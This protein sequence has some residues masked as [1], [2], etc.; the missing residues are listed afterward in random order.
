M[1]LNSIDKNRLN[2]PH[3]GEEAAGVMKQQCNRH[4]AK[5]KDI[6]Q[7]ME[8]VSKERKQRKSIIPSKIN[9][10][11]QQSKPKILV[12]ATCRSNQS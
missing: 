9:V 5:W 3:P 10:K 8:A 12:E 6:F 2:E 4:H 11:P 1:Y 7:N